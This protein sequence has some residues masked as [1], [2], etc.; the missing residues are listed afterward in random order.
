MTTET[1]YGTIDQTVTITLNGLLDNAGRESTAVVN[2]AN[3]FV[4]VLISGVL[5]AVA[6]VGADSFADIYAYGQIASGKYSGSATGT[7][8][9]YSTASGQPGFKNL[10]KLGTAFVDQ[11]TSEQFEWGP[12][13]L[14]D[15]FGAI[16]P[17]WGI[18]VHWVDSGG[19]NVALHSAN[20][21]VNY[22][23]IKFADV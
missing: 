13:S 22:Q 11:P 14:A 7:D 10:I 17:E 6:A 5:E 16:P 19:S 20:N 23:G 1:Q 12:F 18:V 15:A 4:E 8:A 9:A 2:T 21:E 3:K